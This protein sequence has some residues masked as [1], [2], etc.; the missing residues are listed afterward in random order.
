MKNNSLTAATRILLVLC[1]L[2]LIAVLY[3]PMWRIDLSAPQYPEGLKLLIYARKIGGDVDIIN[4][5]NHY[6]GM[7]TLH[8]ADFI[9]FTVLPYIIIFFTAAFMLTALMAKRRVLNLLFILFVLFGV[10]AMVDFWRWEYNYG[11]NLN[12][13][14]AIIVPGMAYQPPLIGYKQLLNFGAYSMPDIGGWIFVAT[15]TLLLGAVVLEWRRSKKLSRDSKAVFAAA[16][17]SIIV[18][19]NSC[20]TKPE[21]IRVGRDNCSFCKMTVSDNRFGA[22]LVTQKGKIYK[23]DD[24]LCLVSFLHAENGV[25]KDN[26]AIYFTDFSNGHALISANGAI[27]Y[28]SDLLQTPMGGHIAAFGNADS[29]KKAAIQ[30]SGSM[31]LWE[32]LSK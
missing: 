15:G 21:P 8:D 22:E 17:L 10:V 4:G 30:Y 5:L 7:K 24:M 27:L 12:P 2:A 1:G 29:M 9:E 18:F 11:H 26:A 32:E 20:N 28:K 25:K 6:I 3:V 14:A 19:L 13:D 16:G 23:F 31:V